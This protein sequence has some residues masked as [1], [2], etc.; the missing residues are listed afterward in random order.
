MKCAICDN[1][2]FVRLYNVL[3]KCCSCGFVWADTSIS[4]E[5]LRR[6]YNGN[7]FFESEYSDYLREKPA[8]QKNF[9]RNLNILKKFVPSGNLL[10]IGCA[11]GFFLDLAQANYDTEGID[12]NE[13]ACMYAK[14]NLKL[15]V[16]CGDFM[17]TDFSKNSYDIIVS[18]ATLEHMSEPNLYIE[19]ISSLL[20]KGGIFCFS[21]IDIKALLPRLQRNKWRQIH[22]PTHLSYFSKK[23]L[24]LLLNKYGL[25]PIYSKH[26][27]ECRSVI[28]LREIL[29]KFPPFLY[30]FE[31][32]RLDR[33][34]VYYNLFDTIYVFASKI[35]S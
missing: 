23:T 32:Y 14:E 25:K 24:F 16:I 7:Y 9:K 34:Y 35:D 17:E 29:K 19:K 6:V 33:F 1:V 22:S 13:N 8:L 27:G 15:N 20:K 26:M 18:W 28:Y 12:I 30:I 3:M 11:Y 10:E 4:K 21:T 5:E 2:V 31:R